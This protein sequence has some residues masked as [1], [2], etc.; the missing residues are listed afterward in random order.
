MKTPNCHRYRVYCNGEEI[1][2]CVEA[3]EE[4][5]YALC[6]ETKDNHVVVNNGVPVR[7]MLRG[8][9]SCVLES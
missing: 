9:V 6:I 5:G 4:A 2:N 1:N 8:I 7:Y 3:N